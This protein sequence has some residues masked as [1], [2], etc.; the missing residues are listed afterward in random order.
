MYLEVDDQPAQQLA[1]NTGWG[2][3]CRYAQSLP[4]GLA[5]T[6]K[7]LCAYGWEHRIPLLFAEI[8]AAAKAS[9]P[10]ETVGTTLSNLQ[11]LLGSTP[12]AVVVAVTNGMTADDGKDDSTAADSSTRTPKPAKAKTPT[13]KKVPAGKPKAAADGGTDKS[14][15][16]NALGKGGKVSGTPGSERSAS[17]KSYED[18]AVMRLEDG[19]TPQL[20]TEYFGNFEPHERELMA[21]LLP[22]CTTPAMVRAAFATLQK[23]IYLCRH[24]QTDASKEGNLRG[25][26]D[27]PINGQGKKDAKT[28]GEWLQGKSVEQVR[29]SDLRRAKQ[30]ARIMM[31]QV[32]IASSYEVGF[33]YRDWSLGLLDGRPEGDA[34]ALIS[35]YV[36]SNRDNA[37]DA[38][39]TF[40]KF[41]NRCLP[42]IQNLMD[43]V[44]DPDQAGNVIALVTHSSVL[45]AVIGWMEAGAKIPKSPTA[46]WEI[47]AT[48]F[49]ATPIGDSQV[50]WLALTPKGW[51][52]KTINPLATDGSEQY[53]KI[54]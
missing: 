13:T 4:G 44:A 40:N 33:W 6:L 47:D 18:M 39:E 26:L 51:A 20:I 46:P 32:G 34:D 1:S 5:D 11:T 35:D 10:P 2:D 53:S 27:M 38:G 36:T 7:H 15:T 54:A 23:G 49:L 12:G 50:V 37:P 31:E 30:S 42:R 22:D 3:V 41:L 16:S 21:E 52:W 9:P 24:A 14:D 45:R 43:V 25:W 28:V 29:R 17:L 19:L 8:A 48:S